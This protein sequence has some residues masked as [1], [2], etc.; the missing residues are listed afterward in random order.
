MPVPGVALPT[1]RLA[2]D[3]PDTLTKGL[4]G[5]RGGPYWSLMFEVSESTLKP[6]NMATIVEVSSAVSRVDSQ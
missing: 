1:L 3:A 2:G 4:G 5:K 6:V